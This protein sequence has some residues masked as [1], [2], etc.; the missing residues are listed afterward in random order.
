MSWALFAD[1]IEKQK[2]LVITVPEKCPNTWQLA[3][4][5]H[6]DDYKISHIFSKASFDINM[7]SFDI[8]MI[9]FDIN[10][11]F[12]DINM[13]SF[14]INMISFDI[15]LISSIYLLT[16]WYYSKWMMGFDEIYQHQAASPRKNC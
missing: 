8:N 2:H 6:R 14:D 9:S 3:I 11:I 15:N 7:S 13:I 5:R 10:M 16:G 12:F 4:S 1:P